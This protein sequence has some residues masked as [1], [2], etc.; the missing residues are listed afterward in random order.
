M[1]GHVRLPEE[2]APG[3]VRASLFQVMTENPIYLLVVAAT[4]GYVFNL[5]RLDLRDHL[6]GRRAANPL[7]GATSVR[8]WWVLVGVAG[9]LALVAIET[10]GE[11]RLGVTEEQTDTVVISLVAWVAAGFVEEL[12]FRGFLFYDRK[13][14]GVLWLSIL[15]ASLLFALLHFQYYLEFPEGGSIP[16][17]VKIDAKSGWSLLILVLNA[18]WFYYLR[19]GAKN[20]KRSLIPCFAAHIASNLGVFFVK[21]AQGH[22]TGWL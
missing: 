7:P 6:R 2:G 16:S 18:L 5:W 22:V 21:L 8:G 19:F 4:A 11:N 14:P 9:A 13:G 1:R 17:G 20:P 10:V 12:I 15:G 3:I